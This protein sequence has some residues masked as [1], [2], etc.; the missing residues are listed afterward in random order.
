GKPYI[1][2]HGKRHPA[3]MGDFATNQIVVRSGKGAKDRVTMLPTTAKPGLIRHLESVRR[4]HESDVRCGAGWVEMLDALARKY[5]NA[6][7]E[8]AG[9]GSSPPRGCTWIESPASAAVITCT[10]QR[11][12]RALSPCSRI[13]SVLLVPRVSCR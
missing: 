6:A 12:V 5:P 9:S 1:F 4:Q 3:D 13:A 11:C 8:W 7:R 2:F 10:S